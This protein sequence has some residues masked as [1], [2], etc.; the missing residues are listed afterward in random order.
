MTIFTVKSCGAACMV[1]GTHSHQA[2]SI[3]K[4]GVHVGNLIN[5]I[6]P[7]GKRFIRIDN[8]NKELKDQLD[9]YYS[10][11]K[12]VTEVTFSRPFG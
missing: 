1:G 9:E 10:S 11:R 4:E 8:Y 12:G 2:F 5:V 3:L 6:D 7:D